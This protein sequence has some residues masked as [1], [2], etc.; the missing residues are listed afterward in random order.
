M[1]LTLMSKRVG[2]KITR[3]SGE[4]GKLR[5]TS[6]AKRHSNS[7]SNLK[8]HLAGQTK[9]LQ[10]YG[11][12]LQFMIQSMHKETLSYDNSMLSTQAIFP[13]HQ[14]PTYTGWMCIW[15]LSLKLLVILFKW[16]NNSFGEESEYM[17]R[18]FCNTQTFTHTQSINGLLL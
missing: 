15:Y 14:Q 10:G 6:L 2:L 17:V 3:D 16:P 12:S 18:K 1:K 13:G 8:N 11:Y 9:Q 4:S 5:S 7:N